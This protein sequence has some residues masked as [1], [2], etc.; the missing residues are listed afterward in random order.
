MKRLF[1]LTLIFAL[2]LFGCDKGPASVETTPQEGQ[3]TENVPICTHADD[4][5]DTVCD[6]CGESVLVCFD[7]YGINDLHGKIADTDSQVG[8][9][10]L[11]SFIKKSR[12][13]NENL[14]LISVGDMWQGSS[15][16]NLTKGLLTTDWMNDI[17]FN[18]MVMGNHE[19]DWGDS[20][21]RSNQA[22][23]QF[24][25]LAINIYDRTTNKQLDY[26]QSSVLVDQNGVQIGII[27]AVGDCYSSIAADK[28]QDIYFKTGDELTRLVKA[29][30]E[31]LRQQG[32]D[33]I[34]YA[35]HDG[36]ENGSGS[37]VRDVNGGQLAGFYD[38]ALSD[39]YVDLVFEGHTHQQYLLRDNHGVYHMQ[40]GGENK[41]GISHAQ[42][43][44]NAVTGESTVISAQLIST[45]EYATMAGDPIVE[46]LLEKYAAEVNRGERVIGYNARQRSSS[47]MQQ[48][49][50]DLYYDVG[51]ETW[52]EEYDI[53]LGGGF[54]S[55]RSPYNLAAGEVNYG[56]VQSLFPFDNQL[57][58]CTIKGRDLRDKFFETDNDRYFIAYGQYGEQIRQ[59]IDPN[60]TYYVVVDS[61]TSS[62]KYNNMT[63]VEVYDD[64]TFARDL[65]AEYISTGAFE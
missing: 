11:T 34:V 52:G 42:V 5:A 12:Q 41:R 64:T 30:S 63:V 1:V 59:N 21:V 10:E 47:E 23:A 51:M 7:I 28:V 31:A 6:S 14:L 45:D 44:L 65:L 32:A 39:G 17:G 27:G 43:S 3:T 38:I 20:F 53:V 61:Y 36:Y 56:M 58:L 37:T 35:I 33:F 62:Y 29:E 15:E 26:C 24:P 55:V 50:A 18:A 2:L 13:E 16:S 9:D 19:Y 57:H 40:N 8:V 49:V 25:Y 22:I 4:N 60:A 54:I 48:L 46:N